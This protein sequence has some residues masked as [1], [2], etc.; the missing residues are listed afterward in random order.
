MGQNLF[1]LLSGSVIYNDRLRANAQHAKCTHSDK[2]N[3]SIYLKLSQST[4]FFVNILEFCLQY[5][6]DTW[7][8]H[9]IKHSNSW[10]FSC[11][12]EKL[13]RV[14]WLEWNKDRFS[15]NDSLI[16]MHKI[17]EKLSN[18][19]LMSGCLGLILPFIICAC[20]AFSKWVQPCSQL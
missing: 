11:Y 15:I 1:F 8:G 16:I 14:T 10:L 6:F 17:L 5:L 20:T 18:A 7:K 19:V 3:R 9:F 13:G 12:L 2:K 4:T